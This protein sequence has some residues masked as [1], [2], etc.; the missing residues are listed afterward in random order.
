MNSAISLPVLSIWLVG[1]LVFLFA[2]IVSVGT[3][4]NSSRIFGGASFA[5]AVWCLALG[6]FFASSDDTVVELANRI[7]FAAGSLIA[8]M[9]FFFTLAMGPTERYLRQ[10][11]WL[12]AFLQSTLWYYL[13]SGVYIIAGVQIGSNFVQREFILGRFGWVFYLYLTTLFIAGFVVLLKHIQSSTDPH[14]AWQLRVIFY[15]S[16]VSVLLSN[17]T[18]VV[19]P[20]LGNF[21]WYWMSPLLILPWLISSAYAIARHHM[22]GVRLALAELLVFVLAAILFI[23]VIGGQQS[24]EIS[25]VLINN[26]QLLP[27]WYAIIGVIAASFSCAI[28]LSNHS[29]KLYFVAGSSAIA[30]VAL[31]Y[32]GLSGAIHTTA[33]PQGILH[34]IPLLVLASIVLSYFA[35]VSTFISRATFFVAQLLII[36]MLFLIAG[37]IIITEVTIGYFSRIAILI[38][39]LISGA[40]FV[41]ATFTE[42]RQRER[43]ALLN[44]R[45]QELNSNLESLVIQRTQEINRA[46]IHAST[47][48]EQLNNGLIETTP[49]SSIIRMNYAAEQLLHTP[50]ESVI[51]KPRNAQNATI[52]TV[53]EPY[54]GPRAE[55]ELPVATL[56]PAAD[57]RDVALGNTDTF[58]RIITIPVADS[59]THIRLIRDIT[60]EIRIS[61][62]KSDFISLVAH[63]LRTPL[64]GIKWALEELI[65]GNAGRMGAK[66]RAR[67]KQTMSMNTILLSLIGDLLLT[68]RI[69]AGTLR[70]EM[71]TETVQ[72]LLRS[73]LS[74]IAILAKERGILLLKTINISVANITADK[75]LLSRAIASVV[76][77]AVRYTREG[78]AVEVSLSQSLSSCAIIIKDNG[79]GIAESEISQVFT[80]FYRSAD[81]IKIHTEGAGLSLYIAKHI[82]E[83]HGGT[84]E[85]R[86]EREHGTAIRIVLPLI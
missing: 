73:A 38:S 86:S 29:R 44:D 27:F 4:K 59:N 47:I 82:I 30:S 72:S 10:A 74:P 45:M 57:L 36:A 67:L 8:T 60:H 35:F 81:A 14:S 26:I 11:G 83:R 34:A 49:D 68:A 77:N 75:E 3:T 20:L 24:E 40:I 43:L 2:T 9:F 23:R 48:I 84:I 5:V 63:Q 64:A 70:Y 71:K 80:K 61:R 56:Q 66:Q 52:Q 39:F 1:A 17:V 79:I 85:V 19:L 69:E 55:N 13:F 28:L 37:N 50:R 7:S 15:S 51:A 65:T 53:T 41:R 21:N 33:V 31:I 18:A 76:D 16:L 62:S 22:F 25:R 78:G 42:E 32:T 6:V 54:R 46:R 58:A 12:I